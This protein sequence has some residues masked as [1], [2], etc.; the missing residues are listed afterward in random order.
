[1]STH[2]LYGDGIHDDTLAIQEQ[3]DSGCSDVSLPAPKVCYLISQALKIHSNQS[4]R[5]PPYSTIKLAADSNCSM[6]ECAN[7][8]VLNENITVEGG[9]WDMNNTEQEPNPYHFPDKN[10]LKAVDYQ[11]A[12]G[13]SDRSKWTEPP[14][15]YTGMCIRL[16][17]IKNLSLRYMTLKN[18]VTYGIQLYKTENFTVKDITF[19][20]TTGAPKLWNMDGIHVEGHC[21]NGYISNLKGA[22][23]DDLVA[24]TTDDLLFGPVKN[25]TVDGIYSDGC[26]SAVRLL[27][28]GL[29][30]EN[31]KISNIYGSFYTYCVG[32]TKY[33]NGDGR[34]TLRNIHIDGVSACAC[35]GT[36]D[37]AGGNFPF[38]WVEAGLD[39]DMLR[40]ENVM[41]RE[42]TYTTPT[43][44]IDAD[45]SIGK[46]IMRNVITEN[47]TEKEFEPLVLDG[48]IGTHVRE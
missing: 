25:I 44:K 43:V 5:L 15:I 12:L 19:D 31:V 3:L 8:A 47:L 11:N 21:K 40:I 13:I 14:P 42:S 48:K 2:T 36:R 18:P 23:H 30:L 34:G 37:V 38:I 17:N 26:H 28:R 41:R 1:M 10:G 20:Y 46:L 27:S 6:L 24:I 45:A 16:S 33:Y 7:F 22:C 32:I 35:Q 4:L 29:S 9:I 39:I